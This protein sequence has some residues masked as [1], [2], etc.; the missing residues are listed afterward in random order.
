LTLSQA[1]LYTRASES[2]LGSQRLF[3]LLLVLSISPLLFTPHAPPLGSP[4]LAL[5]VPL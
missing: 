5:E 3:F 4:S 1:L 2:R